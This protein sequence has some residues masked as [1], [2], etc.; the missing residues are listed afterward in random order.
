MLNL[1]QD[2]GYDAVHL[3]TV[4]KCAGVSLQTIY[5]YFPSRDELIIAAVSDW[6]QVNC[7]STLDEPPA[8]ASLY[9]AVMWLFQQ[10]F[11]PW[12]RDPRMLEV[13]SRARLGPGGD[14]LA[15]QGYDAFAP[16]FEDVVRDLD[17]DY[18]DDVRVILAMVAAAGV[19][20]L[21]G[22]RITVPDIRRTL[23]RALLRLTSD[24]TALLRGARSAGST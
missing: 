1:L 13:Y 20:G 22:G 14:R 4:A 2:D 18:A 12:E 6:M 19:E 17:P 16:I 15:I 7:Y 9:E 11:E 23:E 24:N 5:R 8:F 21:A 10:L 3:R